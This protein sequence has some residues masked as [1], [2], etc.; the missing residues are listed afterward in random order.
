MRFNLLLLTFLLS[1]FLFYAA[2]ASYEHSKKYTETENKLND[3]KLASH[4]TSPQTGA[5]SV[6]STRTKNAVGTGISNANI[7][8]ADPEK[9][10]TNENH[11]RQDKTINILP[12]YKKVKKLFQPP[13]AQAPAP[14]SK[15]ISKKI[16]ISPHPE[17]IQTHETQNS[18][19]APASASAFL[20]KADDFSNSDNSVV[21]VNENDKSGVQPSDDLVFNEKIAVLSDNIDNYVTDTNSGV[22]VNN[23]P[24]LGAKDSQGDENHHHKNIVNIANE[25]T[26]NSLGVTDNKI[27][28]NDD[29]EASAAEAMAALDSDGNNADKTKRNV[30]FRNVTG[31]TERK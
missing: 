15:F 3:A 16:N 24:P 8:T 25:R 13:S 14:A 5:S 1:C 21:D 29:V 18:F 22:N 30:N 31:I 2:L 17:N 4:P 28:S 27:T 11:H 12:N 6:T 26:V 20:N 7:K 10:K 9:L 19:N 23:L